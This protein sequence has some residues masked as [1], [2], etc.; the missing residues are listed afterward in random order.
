MKRREFIHTSLKGM[1]GGMAFTTMA[2]MIQHGSAHALGT[3]GGLGIEEGMYYVEQGKKNNIIPTLRLEILSNPKAVFLI[4]THVDAH[5][6]KDGMYTDAVEQ[7]TQEG[8]R[9]AKLLFRKGENRGGVTFIKPN[10]THVYPWDYDRTT[11]VYSSPDFIGGMV[12]HLRDLGNTNHIAGEGPTGAVVHR[13]GG[14][15]DAFDTYDL[16]MIESGYEWFSHYKKSELNWMKPPTESAIW[17]RIPYFK[18]IGDKGTFMINVSAMKCHMTGLTTLTVKNL[19]GCVPKG[20]GQFCN[21]WDQVESQ[22]RRENID[23]GHDFQKD[24]YQR[25]EAYFLKHRAAG[26]KRWDYFGDYAKYE[27]KGGWEAFRKVKDDDEA[28]NVFVNETGGIMRH[29]IWMHRGL[30]NAAT[31]MPDINI[32]CGIISLDG[33]ELHSNKIGDHMLSNI[34]VAGASPF[35]VDAVGS[36]I[37]GHDPKELWYTR[38]AKERGYGE[39]DPAKIDIYWI[40]EEGPIE[41][42]RDLASIRRQKVGLCWAQTQDPNQRLFW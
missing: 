38:V 33:M 39:C 3:G 8:T 36:W 1:G 28:R 10:F 23:F 25:V 20:Y 42:I 19:Q 6:G 22:A 4:E 5:K 34:V 7:L 31:L 37:M 29:E 2:D 12:T 17:K 41:P 11:G 21:S 9:I 27:A 18:P 24:Y 15:Y 26:F 16:K 30:D 14:V 35:E 40:R 32:I 13:G